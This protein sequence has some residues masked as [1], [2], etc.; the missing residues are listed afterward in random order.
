MKTFGNNLIRLLMFVAI[1]IFIVSCNKKEKNTQNGIGDLILTITKSPILEIN[2]NT[3]K[4]VPLS[5]FKV[6]IYKENGEVYM[7]FVRYGDLPSQITLPAGNYYAIA[8]SANES[9]AAFD[10]PIHFGQ[11]ELFEIGN[12]KVTEVEVVC[13]VSNFGVVIKYSS[14]IQSIYTDYYTVVKGSSDSLIF[15]SGED[16]IGYFEL[17]SVAIYAVLSFELTNGE[18]GHDIIDE[19]I[20]D[21]QAG[22]IYVLSVD[23][24]YEN[25]STGISVTIN[26]DYDT[27]YMEMNDYLAVNDLLEGDLLITEIM[28]DPNNM[29][30][31]SGEWFEIYNNSPSS[32]NL[33]NLVVVSG[34]STFIVDE[35]SILSSG[36]QIVFAS[37]DTAVNSEFIL[38]S[39][40]GLT[41]TS[42]DLALYT[43]GTDGTDGSI[44]ATVA[45]DESGGFPS[46]SGASISLSQDLYDFDLAQLA[47]SWCHISD[48]FYT[49]D[50]GSPGELNPVCQ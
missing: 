39:G 23:A 4:S 5:E 1:T 40:I 29:S 6:T 36:S 3:L 45:Y 35:K 48:T 37:T 46:G 43:Y 8:T 20:S 18:I 49:G 47:S 44:I 22:E 32:I 31:A 30:D 7:E 42:D 38:Y 28:Y 34:S 10:N 15:T 9:A 33:Q 50:Y 24:S 11:S 17:G 12:G 16:R 14:D 21:P 26:N 41:N 13:D 27:I 2:I 25:M 19:N